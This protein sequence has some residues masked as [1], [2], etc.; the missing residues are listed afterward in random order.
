M[1]IALRFLV[2]W[3]L[4][5]LALTV[6]CNEGS[7]TG[8][9]GGEWS[10]QFGF[11]SWLVFLG[12]DGYRGLVASVRS[13]SVAVSVSYLVIAIFAAMAPAFLITTVYNMK[14]RGAPLQ[15][16]L[17]TFI[18]VILTLGGLLGVNCLIWNL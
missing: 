2:V 1:R 9:S 8:Y 6:I 12:S 4:A 3:L 14:I 17:C 18:L 7:E 16:H 5:F 11:P 15:L 13:G 10:H